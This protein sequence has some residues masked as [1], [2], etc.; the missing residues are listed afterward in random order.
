MGHGVSSDAGCIPGEDAEG[1]CTDWRVRRRDCATEADADVWGE[2][3][4]GAE[5]GGGGCAAVFIEDIMHG[6]APLS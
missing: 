2:A 5:W 1:W 4:G 3:C 6:G